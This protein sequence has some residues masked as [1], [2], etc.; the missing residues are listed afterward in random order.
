MAVISLDPDIAAA[1]DTAWMLLSFDL[2]L[3]LAHGLTLPQV[4]AARLR[5]YAASEESGR[6]V[7]AHAHAAGLPVLGG[8]R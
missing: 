4:L 6:G 7:R 1:A 5:P 8:G 3:G 2:G